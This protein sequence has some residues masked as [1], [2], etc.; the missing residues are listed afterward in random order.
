MGVRVVDA[1]TISVC[2][3]FLSLAF[4]RH[5][6]RTLGSVLF[7]FKDKI[8]GG[9]KRDSKR[10]DFKKIEIWEKFSFGRLK[11]RGFMLS[12]LGERVLAY[13]AE[14]ANKVIRQVFPLGSCC[15]AVIRI[16]GSFVINIAT[17]ITYILLHLTVLL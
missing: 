5:T 9:S 4:Y 14:R 2:V 8:K 6:K 15:D 10:G 13:A 11:K 7:V 3:S 12:Q 1:Y 16:A 17:D